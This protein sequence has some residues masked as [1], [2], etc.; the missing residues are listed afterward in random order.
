MNSTDID[1]LISQAEAARD[2]G[3]LAEGLALAEPAWQALGA[4]DAPARR[5]LGL[6]LMHLRY[7]SGA[8][9]KAV[10]LADELLPLLRA[11]GPTTELIDT[12]RMVSLCSADTNRFAL[13][14]S[15]AQEAHRLSLDIGDAIR[16]SLSTNALG[17]F[18]ERSGDPWQAERLMLESVALARQAGDANATRVAL[19]NTGAALIGKFYLLRDAMPPDQAAASLRV[20]RPAPR[21]SRWIRHVV[22]SITSTGRLVLPTKACSRSRWRANSRTR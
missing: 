1:T 11:S 7:R 15:C 22:L 17:C 16:L 14:L 5:R 18:F 20:A 21:L 4:D 9:S 12:L 6:V 10:D 3:R 19:N 13:A 8:V 2:S